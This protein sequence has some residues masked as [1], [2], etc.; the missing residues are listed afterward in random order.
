MI[1]LTA[2]KSQE[3]YVVIQKTVGFMCMTTASHTSAREPCS[4][5]LVYQ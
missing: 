5:E 2:A 1:L 3:A 4:S